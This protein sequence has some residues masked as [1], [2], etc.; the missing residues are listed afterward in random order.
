MCVAAMP[1]EAVIAGSMLRARKYATYSLIVY[2]LPDPGSPVK[3]T[4]E[5]VFNIDSA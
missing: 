1:V 3:K 2:V 5:P 4:F